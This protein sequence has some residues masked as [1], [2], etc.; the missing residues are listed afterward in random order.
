MFYGESLENARQKTVHLKNKMQQIL[1]DDKKEK[2]KEN[3]K[4]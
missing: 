2:K 3:K 4:K 1:E